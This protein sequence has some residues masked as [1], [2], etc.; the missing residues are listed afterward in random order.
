[1]ASGRAGADRFRRHRKEFA[2]LFAV[3]ANVPWRCR[4][5]SGKGEGSCRQ[6][7][8]DGRVS[9]QM[10]Q[11]LKNVLLDEFVE[12]SSSS[13]DVLRLRTMLREPSPF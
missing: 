7:S 5:P 3:D 1:M 9:P 6:M 4:N 13:A 10:I 2:L 11:L 8:C 12:R